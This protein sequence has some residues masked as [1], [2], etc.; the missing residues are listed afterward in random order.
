[1]LKIFNTLGR[2]LQDFK[3]IE[4]GKVR[5]Y[6]CG[7]TVYWTQH[8]GNMRAM[9]LA[10]LIR[11]SLDYLGYSVN[12]VRNYTD[13]GHLTHDNIGEADSG[14][15]R[16]DQAAQR[17][18]LAPDKIASKYIEEF[19]TDVSALNIFEPNEK[20]RAT[21]HIEDITNFIQTLIDKDFAYTTNLGVYFDIAKAKDYTALS[22]QSMEDKL[23]QAG[24]GDVTDSQKKNQSDFA[25]WLFKTGE[26]ANAL[27]TW[28]S[29]FS[30]PEVEEGEGFPGWHIECS[31]MSRKYLGDSIDIHMGGMEHIPIHHTN[32]IA[33]SEAATGQ[34]FVN[35]W[36]HNEWLESAEGKLAKSSGDS[37]SVQTIIDK[38]YDPLALRYLFLNAQYRSKQTFSW[39]ALDAALTSLDN[40]RTKFANLGEAG[41][42]SDSYNAKF[43]EALE[44]D[45]NIPQAL[46]IAW[47][48]LK[49]D[50]SDDSKK[51][52]VLE[53]DKVFGLKLEDFEKE[54]VNVPA[55]INKLI[56]DREAA[57]KSG[58]FVKA[59][60][61]RAKIADKGFELEDTPEG[62]KVSK[63]K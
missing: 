35:Y 12:F 37:L 6:H 13:V 48:L 5:F 22:G 11:R 28:T 24:K 26:H 3:P 19:E 51:A 8:I 33:Q 43:K 10:D 52:T 1:M 31:V 56:I 21:K 41:S 63:S 4:K 46:A 23:G 18:N 40:L 16:M 50:E 29:K 54:E 44:N 60:D 27:Q 53:F 32:E 17:E 15:D 47:D 20:P 2:K 61:L 59:D 62:I 45:F 39:D 9:V 34:K 38:G 36:L 14:I 7:P 57:R 42:V 25:L 58:D 49:S 55:E 30:S